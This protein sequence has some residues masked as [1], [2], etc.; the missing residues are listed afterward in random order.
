MGAERM[1]KKPQ[2]AAGLRDENY[3][4]LPLFGNT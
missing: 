4:H 1:W 2:E 3:T